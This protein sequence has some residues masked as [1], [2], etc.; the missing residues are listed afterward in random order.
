MDCSHI[1]ITIWRNQGAL[2]NRK[3]AKTRTIVSHGFEGEIFYFDTKEMHPNV[4]ALTRLVH[5]NSRDFYESKLD[6]L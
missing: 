6:E 4:Q 1:R 2:P 5:V 3:K